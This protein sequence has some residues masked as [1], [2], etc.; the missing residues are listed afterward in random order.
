MGD[1]KKWE[2]PSNGGDDL[3]MG[4]GGV[5]TLLRTFTCFFCFFLLFCSGKVGEKLMHVFIINTEKT[6]NR[7]KIVA[8]YSD[9]VFACVI[10]SRI[11]IL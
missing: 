1:F 4:G 9:F 8:I 2:D 3:E 10:N 5:D 11:T 6:V 7:N